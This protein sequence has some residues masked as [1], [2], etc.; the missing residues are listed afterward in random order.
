MNC[1]RS[2]G[3]EIIVDSGKI[4]IWLK[5]SQVIAIPSSN[6][7]APYA[8]IKPASETGLF[9]IEGIHHVGE[10]IQAGWNIETLIYSP[11]LL[12]S[13]FG[14]SQVSDLSHRGIR[15]V[16]LTGDLFAILAGKDNPQGIL[17][18]AHQR[19]QTLENLSLHPFTWGVACVAPQDPGNVGTILRTLDAVG[20]DGL[21]IL[22]GGVELYHPSLIRASMGTLFWKPVVQVSFNAFVG[23]AHE[24]DVQLVGSSAHAIIDYRTLKRDG[25]TTILLLGNEQKGLTQDQIAACDVVVSVPMKGRGSSLNLAVATGILLYALMD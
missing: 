22:D 19:I 21:F 7:F 14:L 12:T 20:A 15:C 2:S 1:H 10:A 13:E 5:Y 17:A 18:I 24:H 11:E 8:S 25:R 3:W 9:L 23:W 4:Y 6:K 16:G